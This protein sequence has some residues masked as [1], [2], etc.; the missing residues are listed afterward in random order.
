M[1]NP[2]QIERKWQDKW[3]K[4]KIFEANPNLNKTKL[5]Y[6]SKSDLFKIDGYEGFILE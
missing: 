4:A 3:E 2:K 1:Y 5:K 6:D